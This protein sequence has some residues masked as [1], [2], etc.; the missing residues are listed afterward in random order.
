MKKLFSSTVCLLASIFLLSNFRSIEIAMSPPPR[1]RPQLPQVPFDY[2]IHFPGFVQEG[3]WNVVDTNKVNS[4]ITNEV[5]TLGRVLFYDKLLSANHTISCSSC[6]IQAFGFADTTQFSIGINDSRTTR[7]SPSLIDIAWKKELSNGVHEFLFWDGRADV[8]E[9]MVLMPITHN[10]ELGNTFEAVKGNMMATDYYQPLFKAA[11]GDSIIT[12]AKI[13]KALAQFIRSIASFE[14]KFDLLKRQG[15]LQTSDI[16]QGWSIFNSKCGS[17]CHRPFH[18]GSANPMNNGLDSVFT[19]LGMIAW[20]NEDDDIGKFRSPSLRNIAVTAPY[21]HDGRFKTLSEVV[22]F[23]SEK[24][25]NLPNA[26]PF[27]G[28]GWGNNPNF[29]GFE[30]TSSEKI[31]LINFLESLTDTVLLTHEKWSDPFKEEKRKPQEQ[32]PA[33]EE[34]IVISPNPFSAFLNVKINYPENP[35]ATLQLYSLKGVLLKEIKVEGSL[36]VLQRDDLPQGVYF[37]KIWRNSTVTVRRVV[38][39]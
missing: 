12:K 11:Y 2:K 24:I 36:G 37:L 38:V 7:N 17:T 8:L 28:G 39:Q 26:G 1:H 18:F 4:K 10:G 35:N 20:T 16:A 22:D 19:D 34:D 29:K 21:M 3:W 9:D 5:A 23:Y 30:F 32:L 13:G 31:Q 6:H 14:S 15:T 25:H 33:K 27:P